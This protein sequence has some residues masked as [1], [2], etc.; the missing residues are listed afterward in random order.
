MG[1]TND[2]LL[3]LQSTIL[4]KIS[5]QLEKK[6]ASS[7]RN[8]LESIIENELEQE[9]N[10]PE[11]NDYSNLTVEEKKQAEIDLQNFGLPINSDVADNFEKALN[12]FI[13]EAVPESI[14]NEL[15]KKNQIEKTKPATQPVGAPETQPEATTESQS[16]E[17]TQSQSPEEQPPDEE[18]PP[19]AA[20]SEP[21]SDQSQTETPKPEEEDNQ[22]QQKPPS[23]ESTSQTKSQPTQPVEQTEQQ[24]EPAEEQQQKGLI[25]KIKELFLK[26]KIKQI[27]DM[28]REQIRPLQQIILKLKKKRQV[29]EK[30]K[31]LINAK[32]AVASLLFAIKIVGALF[33][34]LLGI[35]LILLVP[36]ALSLFSS[37][38][39]ILISAFMSYT[40]SLAKYAKERYDINKA[41]KNISCKDNK[42]GGKSY[43]AKSI[44]VKDFKK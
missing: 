38:T 16:T 24:P 3:F 4:K 10:H 7:L 40:K 9:K 22:A 19:E 14:K 6:D 42:K 29:L 21:K 17:A 27:L 44:Y 5:L 18:Q 12:D 13:E 36:I 26:K 35:I 37:G 11:K 23:E 30:K 8:T 28:A 39:D 25:N 15:E 43:A 41:I 33:L 32:I 31:L 20:P 34:F 1:K 2:F